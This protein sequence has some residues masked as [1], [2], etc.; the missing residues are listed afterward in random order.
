MECTDC[1]FAHSLD[2]AEETGLVDTKEIGFS[3]GE[4]TSPCVLFCTF[5]RDFRT[6]FSHECE[7]IKRLGI[8]PLQ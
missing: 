7:S 4:H 2:W 3:S 8:K 5:N 1:R 6:C